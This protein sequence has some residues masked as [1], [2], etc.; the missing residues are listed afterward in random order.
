MVTE[1]GAKAMSVAEA[2][3]KRRSIRAFGSE[4]V[5]RE[6]LDAIFDVTRLA[7]SA[8]NLQPWRFVVVEDPVRKAQLAEAAFNQRQVSSASFI[9]LRRTR[10]APVH[11][12]RSS[13]RSRRT[14]TRSAKPGPRARATSR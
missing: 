13:A 9:P 8:W 2:A 7:P 11:G 14:P 3:A 5:P 12:D 10:S 4:R 1:T 6:D